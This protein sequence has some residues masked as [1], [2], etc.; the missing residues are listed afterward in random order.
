MSAIY[1]LSMNSIE[2]NPVALSN[3]RNEALLI[4]NLASQ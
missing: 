4:V 3:Y 1:E 2:G